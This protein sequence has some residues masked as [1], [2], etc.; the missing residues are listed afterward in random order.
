M[1]NL[2]LIILTIVVILCF[3]A[4]FISTFNEFEK[5]EKKNLTSENSRGI[6]SRFLAYLESLVAD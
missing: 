2:E 3:V 6:L 4:F 5:V 1:E